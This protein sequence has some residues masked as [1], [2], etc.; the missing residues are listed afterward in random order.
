MGNHDKPFNWSIDR[1]E[2]LQNQLENA[3]KMVATKESYI[4][5]LEAALAEATTKIAKLEKAYIAEAMR[6]VE[7]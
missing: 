3:Q 7:V 4:A 2:S 5:K 1:I 6:N